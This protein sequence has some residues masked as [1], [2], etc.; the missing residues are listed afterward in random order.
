MNR[1]HEGINEQKKQATMNALKKRVIGI[2]EDIEIEKKTFVEMD[3]RLSSEIFNSD[4]FKSLQRD[5]QSEIY[6]FI[7]GQYNYFL[8]INTEVGEGML[9]EDIY[10]KN[11]GEKFYEV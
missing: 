11:G 3:N 6:G 5:K 10:Y 9:D 7:D 2:F 1:R 4:E 8:R